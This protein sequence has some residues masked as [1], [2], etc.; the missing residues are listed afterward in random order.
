MRITDPLDKHERAWFSN[1]E[2]AR[3]RQCE[4]IARRLLDHVGAAKLDEAGAIKCIGQLRAIRR[5][6]FFP[7][8]LGLLCDHWFH[9]FNLQKGTVHE[10]QLAGLANHLLTECENQKGK[11]AFWWA[12]QA[13]R[14]K[15]ADPKR[16]WGSI[17][18]EL[19][20]ARETVQRDLVPLLK[21]LGANKD[22]GVRGPLRALALL[23]DADPAPS[24][25]PDVEEREWVEFVKRNPRH[26]DVLEWLSDTRPKRHSKKTA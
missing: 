2:H 10:R 9:L 18:D 19:G 14:M 23:D 3:R 11:P 25:P 21:R 5:T 6:P 13:M 17:A 20:I 16:A 26:P 4:R 12:G 24:S 7:F 1:A 8:T 15:V 22:K